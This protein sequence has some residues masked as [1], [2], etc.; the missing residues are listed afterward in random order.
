MEDVITRNSYP[1]VDARYSQVKAGGI[2]VNE[3]KIVWNPSPS[4]DVTWIE[5]KRSI[6]ILERFLRTAAIRHSGPNSII[7]KPILSRVLVEGL[8]N[9]QA[10][11]LAEQPTPFGNNL[12]LFHIPVVIVIRG[13]S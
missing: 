3:P 10:I 1:Q 12:E 6:I 11:P 2:S 9:F 7:K 4:T 5:L 8:Y 13:V